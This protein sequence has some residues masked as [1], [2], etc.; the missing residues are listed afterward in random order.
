MRAP[1]RTTFVALAATGLIALTGCGGSDNSSGSTDTSGGTTSAPAGTPESSDA[2]S[3][4]ESTK[5]S[6]DETKV[7]I[8]IKD[9]AFSATDPIA[10]GTT[11][12]VT[13]ADTEAHTVTSDDGTSFDVTIAP[14][15]TET[16]TA[17]SE[18]GDYAYH[19]TY[20]SNMHGALTVS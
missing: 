13:N 5:S 10:P 2:S 12:T 7:E 1:I 9:F 3:A 14:G 18:A 8:M 19:C 4:A 16:F 15:A 11:I 20:H 17:P 6:A